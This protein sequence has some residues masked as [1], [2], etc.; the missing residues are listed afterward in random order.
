[1]V[2]INTETEAKE[3]RRKNAARVHEA[4]AAKC[5]R[6]RRIEDFKMARE[7]GVSIEDLV[8]RRC[9]HCGHVNTRSKAAKF[10]SDKCRK[11]DYDRRRTDR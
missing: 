8:T 6:R 5:A 1:M 11:A 3:I 10:C 9:P 7:L 4:D 2:T